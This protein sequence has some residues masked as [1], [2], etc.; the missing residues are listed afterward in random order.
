M[1]ALYHKKAVDIESK[2]P[3]IVVVKD[4]RHPIR[5]AETDWILPLLYPG[6]I[7]F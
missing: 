6:A 4:S 3:K 2:M 7:G 1:R 5:P